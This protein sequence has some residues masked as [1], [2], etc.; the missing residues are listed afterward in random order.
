M[1]CI[2]D[3]EQ[4]DVEQMPIRF[5]GTPAQVQALDTF[6]KL[7]RAAHTLAARLGGPMLKVHGLTESQLG[8]LEALHHLGPMPQARLCD[9]LLTSGSNLTTVLDNLE[10]RGW[11]RRQADPDD[12]RVRQVHLTDKGAKVIGRAFPHHVA[13]VTALLGALTRE[14]QKEL[15]RLCRKLGLASA[16]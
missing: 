3:V 4:C 14:E 15:A 8:V 9:K 10:R 16:D 6:V 5:Q 11:I 7:T 1:R 13:N 2:F 12:R